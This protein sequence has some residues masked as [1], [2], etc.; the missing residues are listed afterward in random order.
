MYLTQAY[1]NEVL[2][3]EKVTQLV[4]QSGQS[5]ARTI[6]LAEAEVET[7]LM[8][9]GYET[10]VPSSVY[11]SLP[12]AG[13]Q[14]TSAQCPRVIS[15]LAY[16]AWLEIVHGGAALEMPAQFNAYVKK[17]DD[18]RNGKIE[19]P[20]ASKGGVDKVVARAVGGTSFTDSTSSGAT[21]RPPVFD[22]QS[23]KDS[24]Y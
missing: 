21:S 19:L 23:L 2:G 5:I 8:H 1:L 7:V 24:G 20:P 9:A 6:D 16:G 12:G 10:A 18:V 14:P 13:S 3:T 4:G 15:L 11:A 17:L 22:R